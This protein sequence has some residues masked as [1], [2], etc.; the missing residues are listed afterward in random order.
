ME[1]LKWNFLWDNWLIG[2]RFNASQFH[3]ICLNLFWPVNT[4]IYKVNQRENGSPFD[5]FFFF[6]FQ[7]VIISEK[8]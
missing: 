3:I 4:N 7:K 5:R 2:A 1:F 8:N 6:F